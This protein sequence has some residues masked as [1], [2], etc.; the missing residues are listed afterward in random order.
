MPRTATY[1]D[2]AGREWRVREIVSYGDTP[3]VPG[4]LP[5]VARVAVI[6]EFGSARLI[7]DDAPLDW[8]ARPGMLEALFA[9][10]RLPSA[11]C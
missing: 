2:D 11:D 4:E 3:L 7:A 1:T 10:A 5:K 9:R 8:C 6:F